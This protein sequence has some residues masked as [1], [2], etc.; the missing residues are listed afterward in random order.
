[1]EFPKVNGER[2]K[3][4]LYKCEQFFD[5][6]ETPESSKVKLASCKLEG[7]AYNDIDLS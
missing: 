6:D 1:M 5:V 4:L 3:D 7:K 2:L